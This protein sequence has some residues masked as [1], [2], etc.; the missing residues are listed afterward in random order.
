[1][2]TS[3]RLSGLQAVT[4][5]PV[6]PPVADTMRLET[7][8]PEEPE[9]GTGAVAP[10][11]APHFSAGSTS[12]LAQAGLQSV[13][14]P[15]DTVCVICHLEREGDAVTDYASDRR[16]AYVDRSASAHAAY[17]LHYHLVWSVRARARS[18]SA[19]SPRLAGTVCSRTVSKRYHHSRVAH[20]ARPR[21]RVVRS[22]AQRTCG[23]GRE[24]LK[25][26]SSATF[27]GPSRHCGLRT[28]TPS[29]TRDTL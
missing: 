14:C 18:S 27:V 29:G 21:A 7:A 4:L 3:G 20:R 15:L 24:R 5:E 26:T 22:G 8:I 11:E 19:I 17:S 28:M 12:L 10:P 6:A 23:G 2:R 1:M 13:F 16:R 25:G 9:T